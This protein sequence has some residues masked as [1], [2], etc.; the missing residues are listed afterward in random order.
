MG[1]KANRA[2]AIRVFSLSTLALVPVAASA[3]SGPPASV[4][5]HSSRDGNNNIYVMNPD[6]SVPTRLTTDA[7]NDQRADIS[8]DGRQIVF[9]SSRNDHFELFV[10]NADGSG[11]R[12]L[13]STPIIPPP[14]TA[15]ANSWPRWSPDGE[16]IA[17]Q[18]TSDFHTNAVVPVQVWV[19]HPDGT[20]LTRI[21]NFTTNQFPA[22]SPDGTRLAVRRDV[23]VYII[24]LVG[25]APPLR[26]TTE[27]PLNQMP[28]WSPDGTR[29]AFMSTRE[30]GNYPS[31]FVMNADGTNQVDLTPKP[32][33]F[34]GTWSSRAPAWSPNGKKIYFTA[35]RDLTGEQVYV[36]DADGGN[37]RALTTDGVNAEA[38]VRHVTPPAITNISATPNVLWPPNNR[39]TRVSVDVAVSDNSDPMP[40]CQ[41]TDVASN[42]SIAGSAWEMQGPLTLNL[43]ADR[44][45]AGP[46]RT[47]TLTVTCTNS[48]E[49]SSTAMV[50]VNVPH[51]RGK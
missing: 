9:A 37:P 7:S 6:G 10:M 16:W 45:G 12:Q 15:I 29:I 4:A 24:D 17:F 32:N 48:S 23:D 3:Q 49:L 11:V 1:S 26:L 38:T 46:G 5:F 22:W 43:A 28:S 33:L 21:T 30:P 40:A 27:G 13:T 42:E 31:V 18:S 25:G 2:L 14:A 51:D 36:M 41:I 19:I 39:M 44:H 35:I 20:G 34:K 47:Y 50:T 8:P